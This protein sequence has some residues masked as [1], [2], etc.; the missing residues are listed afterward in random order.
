MCFAKKRYCDRLGAEAP[1]KEGEGED[2]GYYW[3]SERREYLYR[4]NGNVKLR[5]KTGRENKLNM[6]QE[7]GPF[8]INNNEPEWNPNPKEWQQIGLPKG[9]VAKLAFNHMVS[10]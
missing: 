8:D 7:T 10:S 6:K 1:C 2:K 3:D 5:L 9:T 4:Y